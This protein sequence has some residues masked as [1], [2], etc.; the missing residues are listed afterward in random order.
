MDLDYSDKDSEI[1]N[2]NNGLNYRPARFINTT[3]N[4]STT[5]LSNTNTGNSYSK[6][7]AFWFRA[8]ERPNIH[9]GLH[10]KEDIALYSVPWNNNVFAGES[11]HK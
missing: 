8:K 6:S 1:I 11:K 10:Y 2:T 7:A 3:D 5:V 9:I 4:I